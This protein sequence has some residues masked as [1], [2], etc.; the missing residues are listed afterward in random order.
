[1]FF[2]LFWWNDFFRPPKKIRTLRARFRPN[3][4]GIDPK[5]LLKPI[6]SPPQ[7]KIFD[8][9][10]FKNVFCFKIWRFKKIWKFP[11]NIFETDDFFFAETKI[12][13]FFSFQTE[14]NLFW[15]SRLRYKPGNASFAAF[16]LAFY[17]KFRSSE[18]WLRRVVWGVLGVLPLSFALSRLFCGLWPLRT[19]NFR[20]R[21][22]QSCLK[23][24]NSTGTFLKMKWRR[25][26]STFSNSEWKAKYSE[27]R[28]SVLWPSFYSHL[29]PI[30]KHNI[31]LKKFSAKL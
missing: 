9:L 28:M 15:V 18:Q 10:R 19:M 12:F 22:K 5:L 21:E 11:E 16:F 17:Q 26:A 3:S 24:K 7:A 25:Y 23:K 2:Y 6:F 20:F 13:D 4:I 1:M 29:R 31:I 30:T 8:I 14:K 27:Y